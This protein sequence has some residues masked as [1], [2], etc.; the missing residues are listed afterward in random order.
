MNATVLGPD[1]ST[2]LETLVDNGDGTGVRTFYDDGVVT[3]TEEVTGLP[4]PVPEPDPPEVI[5]AAAIAA[6]ID[7]RL[8]PSD[9][10]S[11]AE[12][13]T[14]IR[15]GLAAAVEALRAGA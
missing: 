14:A 2:V 5:A 7:S 11:I 8:A 4:L 6:E 13:K 9:V 3:R 12:V 10:N 15:Q 1:G